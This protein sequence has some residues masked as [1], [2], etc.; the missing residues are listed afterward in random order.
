MHILW[1]ASWL[2]LAHVLHAMCDIFGLV[3]R[4]FD[5]LILYGLVV[6]HTVSTCNK[7]SYVYKIDNEK[8]PMELLNVSRIPCMDLL[9]KQG[10]KSL[11]KFNVR[12]ILYLILLSRYKYR[13]FYLLKNITIPYWVFPITF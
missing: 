11:I 13:Y 3:K 12:H 8:R 10:E 5:A 9:K 6:T 7:K 1:I 4:I 2:K